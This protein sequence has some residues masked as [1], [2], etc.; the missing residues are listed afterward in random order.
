MKQHNNEVKQWEET[1]LG[2]VVPRF[3][4]KL[5]RSVHHAAW[6]H[7]HR[8]SAENT[9]N[10]R[11]IEEMTSM[12]CDQSRVQLGRGWVDAIQIHQAFCAVGASLV[13]LDV[14]WGRD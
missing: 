7:N 9:A 1:R 3:C 5:R 2:C 12:P 4:E 11:L 14:R 8:K 6:L 13:E 10:N